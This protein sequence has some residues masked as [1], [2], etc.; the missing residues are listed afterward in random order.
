VTRNDDI[1]A[2]LALIDQIDAV[3][4]I[5]GAMRHLTG[6]GFVVVVHTTEERWVVCEALD[7]MGTGLKRGDTLDLDSTICADAEDRR[8]PVVIDRVSERPEYMDHV[9]RYKLGFESFLSFPIILQD[10]TVFGTLCG[11][12]PEPRTLAG[13]PVIDTLGFFAEL[14]ATQIDNARR[15]SDTRRSLHDEQVEAELR[16]QFI[17]VLGHDLRN[18]VASITSG[19]RML[20]DMPLSAHAATITKLMQG[21]ALRMNGLIDNLLDFARGRLGG[22]IAL[23]VDPRALL[24]PVLLQVVEELRAP[25]HHRIDTHLTF[26]DPVA[27]DAARIGQLASNLIGNAIH[28][29][30]DD[31]PV[32]VTAWRTEGAFHLS[33]ANGGDPIPE[34][35]RVGLFQPFARGRSD[36]R[37]GLGLGLY[38][39]A[40]IARAH[41]GDIAC[42]STDEETRF[43]MTIPA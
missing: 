41:G 8:R 4:K 1:Q 12:D 43:T 2:A 36:H 13:T 33:V 10:G 7:A 21:S 34:D 28:H 11:F 23:N 30:A 42:I 24:R 32:A 26:R 40:E 31:I 29:G 16:E 17:A 9:A 19:T 18:P 35:A 20:L 25:T 6:M 37:E 39:A 38:I 22:G 15:L 3:P 14:V 5:L 27:C